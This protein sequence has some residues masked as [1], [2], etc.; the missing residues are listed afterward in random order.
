MADQIAGLTSSDV[1]SWW[2][3]VFGAG[4][5]GAI[6]LAWLGWQRAKS[7]ARRPPALPPEDQRAIG[8]ALGERHIVE[9]LDR[10]HDRIGEIAR[11]IERLFAATGS[12]HGETAEHLRKLGD[13]LADRIERGIDE[14]RDT[15]RAVEDLRSRIE[16]DRER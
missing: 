15:R 10:L 4:S 3:T 1:L 6:F 5:G 2:V 12:H 9:Q 16:D 8:A 13:R 14:G 11:A 7:E